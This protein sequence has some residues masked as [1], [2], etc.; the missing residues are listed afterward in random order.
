MQKQQFSSPLRD[1]GFKKKIIP[2]YSESQNSF[3]F[4]IR[5]LSI[6]DGSWYFCIRN[7]SFLQ[8]HLSK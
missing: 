8:H 6:L 4:R 3:S 7:N 1:S 2:S 5:E